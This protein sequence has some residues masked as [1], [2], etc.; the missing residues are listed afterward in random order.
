MNRFPFLQISGEPFDRGRQ[1]GEQAADLIRFNL[2]GY[3]RMFQHYSGLDRTAAM[4]QACLYQGPIE[5]HAPDLLREMQGIAAGAGVSLGE[6][7][8]LNCRT[9]LLSVANVPLS[10]ECTAIYVAPEMTADGHALLAQNWDWSDIL[11]GGMVLMRIEQPGGPTVLTLAEAGM[12][13]KCGLNS[14]GVGVCVNFLRHSR[15]RIGLPFHLILRQALDAQRLGLAA[16][17]VI[18]ADR[19]DSGNFL[20]AHADG[21]AVNLESTPTT[22]SWQHPRNGLLAHTNHFLSARLQEGDTGIQESDNTLV[23]YGR[24]V[25]LLRGRAGALTAEAVMEIL[26][27]HF[28]RPKSICRHPDTTIARIEQ[29]ATLASMVLDLTS[30]IMHVAAGEPCQADYY[31]VD[32][33]KA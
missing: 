25:R 18:Q 6:I 13:G 21:E 2:D 33:R 9:E 11:R 23:R 7:L 30:G 16:A 15:R 22:V 10:Q 4:E 14:S 27:D 20:V 17:A 1:H 3:W 32:L 8:A 28:D 29:S 24:A 31:S 19:A 26:R 5:R 12:V